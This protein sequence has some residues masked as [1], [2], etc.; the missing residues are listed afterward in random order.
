VCLFHI[1]V[2]LKEKLGIDLHVAHLNHQLRGA[3]SES[4]ARYVFELAQTLGLPATVEKRDVRSYQTQKRISLEEAAREVRYNFLAQIAQAIGTSRV[5]IGHTRD[6]N[7]ETILMHLIRGSGTRGLQGLQPRTE[8][9]MTNGS[10]TII[11]PL[12]SVSREETAGYCEEQNLTPRLDSSN[13]SLSP[14]RNR[15][16]LKL[17]PRL[18]SYNPRIADA[19]LRTARIAA[20]DLAFIEQAGT[21]L[22]AQIAQRQE[23]TI[24]LDKEHFL[25]LP[26]ALKRLLLRKSLGK[27]IGNLKD[28]EARHIEGIMEALN[29]PAGR[30]LNLPGGLSFVIEYDRYLIGQDPLAL[31]PFPP[32]EQELPLT[33]PGRTTL[34]GSQIE[35]SVI[36]RAQMAE[37]S[38]NLTACLDLGKT[39][40][41]LVVRSRKH[42]DRF[43]PLG[44]SQPKKL[45]E[46]MIDSKIPRA[47]RKNVPIV[48]SPQQ[49]IWVVGWRIDDRVKVTDN[50]KQVLCLKFRRG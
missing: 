49:I 13:L 11:R 24:I 31:S 45:K 21:E 28:I 46:F 48:C 15:I 33:I 14:L 12:L 35:A 44:M 6:D 37:R 16:R 20:D 4:D 42:G 32:L 25:E 3:E 30:S 23:D 10:L 7:I 22:W 9:Q 40:D 47:W 8:W 29:K 5:A 18:K 50:T 39:G 43:Q 27:L 41:K 17:L 34:S 38:D 2:K 36:S 19:L 1:L 26:P